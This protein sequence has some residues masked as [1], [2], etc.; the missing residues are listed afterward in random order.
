MHEPHY[1]IEEVIHPD[2][3][4]VSGCRMHV[5]G[6]IA[7]GYKRTGLM[8]YHRWAASFWRTRLTV[9]AKVLVW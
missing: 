5:I 4:A 1:V 7:R 3:I 9:R 6:V 2:E 8:C